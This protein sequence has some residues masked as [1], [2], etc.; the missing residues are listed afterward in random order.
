MAL[1]YE[2]YAK[3]GFR[4]IHEGPAAECFSCPLLKA[5]AGRLEKGRLY[6]VTS[7]REKK[8]RCKI[9]EE[10]VRVV[11]VREAPVRALIPVKLAIQS[12]V[13]TFEPQE[14]N[15]LL[16]K[17]YPL[18]RPQGL[19]SGDKCKVLELWNEL[20]A[21]PCGKQLVEATLLRISS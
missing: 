14:C 2:K 21:L 20:D 17:Y 10:G 18:C 13:I 15:N 9:H 12:A 8:H 6:E 3:K 11:E 16:C 4:F 5:C 1:I 7:L 19:K